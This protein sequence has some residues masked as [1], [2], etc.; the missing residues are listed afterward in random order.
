MSVIILLSGCKINNED[1]VY[2]DNPQMSYALI[3]LS[4]N[5]GL[6]TNEFSFVSDKSARWEWDDGFVKFKDSNDNIYIVKIYY[7]DVDYR[8]S[9]NSEVLIDTALS[10]EDDFE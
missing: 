7:N 3:V 8:I 5:T 10:K 2:Y 9:I 6:S 4:N 1:N